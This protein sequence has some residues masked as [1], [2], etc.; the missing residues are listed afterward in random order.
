[1]NVLLIVN[2]SPWASSLANTALRFART[3]LAEGACVSAVFFQGDGV[4][5][6]FGG[7]TIDPGAEDLSQAWADLARQGAFQLLLCSSALARRIPLK[8][9]RDLTAPYR[10]AGLVEMIELLDRSDRVLSF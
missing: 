6:A 7:S 2:E 10:A 3:A 1:M 8:Q 5:N 9:G 4:Y